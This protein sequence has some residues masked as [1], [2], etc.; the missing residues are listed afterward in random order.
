MAS[1]ALGG[2]DVLEPEQMRAAVCLPDRGQ[3]ALMYPSAD[4]AAAAENLC[5]GL[6][7][8][9]GEQHR[10]RVPFATDDSSEAR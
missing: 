9:Q 10:V 4:R 3:V 2:E 1:A 8:G 7:G 5:G 6:L